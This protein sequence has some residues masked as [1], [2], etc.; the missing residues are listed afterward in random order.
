[1]KKVFVT[2]A[3]L[4]ILGTV[5]SIAYESHKSEKASYGIFDT[6]K[7]ITDK[8]HNIKDDNVKNNNV[9]GRDIKDDNIKGHDVE[10]DRY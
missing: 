2:A 10:D 8:D 5:D 9:K 4:A 1:M 7:P 3:L 6:D